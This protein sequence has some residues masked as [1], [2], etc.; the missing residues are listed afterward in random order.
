[1]E[2]NLLIAFKIFGLFS[3]IM[4]GG[5]Y[6]FF[7]DKRVPYEVRRYVPVLIGSFLLFLSSNILLPIAFDNYGQQIESQTSIKSNDS[8]KNITDKCYSDDDNSH[9]H[10]RLLSIVYDFI[11]EHKRLSA[12]VSGFIATLIIIVL[13]IKKSKKDETEESYDDDLGE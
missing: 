13:K 8:E 1:M 6:L 12:I 10:K 7:I 11:S 9:E 4:S 3:I 2:A 5:I